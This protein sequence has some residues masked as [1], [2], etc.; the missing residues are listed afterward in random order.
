MPMKR[1]PLRRRGPARQD[2]AHEDPSRSSEMRR[3]RQRSASAQPSPGVGGSC[4]GPIGGSTPAALDPARAGRMR[5]PALC[6]SGLLCTSPC[7]PPGRA[8]PTALPGSGVACTARPRHAFGQAGLVGAL[9]RLPPGL[10]SDARGDWLRRGGR[11]P[12]G[13]AA[14]MRGLPVLLGLVARLPPRLLGCASPR[15]LARLLF[16]Q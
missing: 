2:P 6:D 13:G 3:W 16:G 15:A 9:S 12:G 1:A 11:S 14:R 8:R 4:A 5:R 7:L 10:H